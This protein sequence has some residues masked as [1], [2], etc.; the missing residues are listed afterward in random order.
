MLQ[1]H[2]HF[3]LTLFL[4]PLSVMLLLM[5]LWLWVVEK[6]EE[7]CRRSRLNIIRPHHLPCV[8][9]TVS[10]FSTVFHC[11]AHLHLHLTITKS[12]R[13]GASRTTTSTVSLS[14]VIKLAVLCIIVVSWT[15]M[16]LNF[17]KSSSSSSSHHHRKPLLFSWRQSQSFC[18][19]S[20]F[21]CFFHT[22]SLFSILYSSGCVFVYFYWV[23]FS[24]IT[25]I[26]LQIAFVW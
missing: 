13:A 22:L 24:L 2:H 12:E 23:I 10:R 14:A 17:C 3:C 4:F 18:F 9:T 11:V 25:R 5:L 16:S 20:L 21:S 1:H 7:N 8:C 19:F 6:T 15:L 26:K